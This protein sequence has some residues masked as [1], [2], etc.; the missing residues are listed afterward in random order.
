M[1]LPHSRAV[2]AAHVR[3]A[4]LHGL[5]LRPAL[6]AVSASDFRTS[7]SSTA[8]RP[9]R[10]ARAGSTSCR[11]RRR[12]PITPTQ[13][14]GRFV[15]FQRGAVVGHRG[16]GVQADGA[17]TGLSRASS[18]GPASTTWASRRRSTARR[19]AP[20]SAS[21]TCAAFPRIATTCIAA[22]GGPMRRRSTSCRTGTG[23]TASG[24]NVPVFVYTN[25]DS[26]E[27]FLN[28]KSLG[29][30]T[31]GSAPHA[32]GELGA[33]VGR[34]RPARPKAAIRRGEGRRTATPTRGGARADDKADQWCRSTWASRGRS[35]A[36]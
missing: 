6:R 12:R 27:L 31:K 24:K 35:S 34:R 3:P 10:S 17:T 19:R 7:R 20:I 30:R 28:G 15:R 14:P 26:A 22:T 18:C 5:E 25:G 29:R 9:R 4:R 23:R 11:C 21:S 8:S 16:R 1:A 2:A 13:R 33:K 36:W 32:A